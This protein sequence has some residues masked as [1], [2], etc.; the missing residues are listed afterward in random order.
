LVGIGRRTRDS[1]LRTAWN[2]RHPRR[3][4]SKRGENRCWRLKSSLLDT[5]VSITAVASAIA[6]IVGV[7][8]G[9]YY[10]RRTD[11]IRAEKQLKQKVLEVEKDLI[12]RREFLVPL[13]KNQV[14][15]AVKKQLGPAYNLAPE[16]SELVG[17]FQANPVKD[18]EKQNPKLWKKLTY[19]YHAGEDS[20]F[21]EILH[22]VIMDYFTNLRSTSPFEVRVRVVS[23]FDGE[24]RCMGECHPHFYERLIVPEFGRVEGDAFSMSV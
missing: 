21:D 1:S 2:P 6:V 17:V 23:E 3:L 7:A 9:I 18:L 5:T 11:K 12:V 8:A 14:V 10:Q 19:H 22:T 15:P 20:K 24:S 4:L 13:P 16:S